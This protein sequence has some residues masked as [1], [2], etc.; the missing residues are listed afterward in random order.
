MTGAE[1]LVGL[2]QAAPPTPPLHTEAARRVQRK[3]GGL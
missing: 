1:A 2:A 3:G